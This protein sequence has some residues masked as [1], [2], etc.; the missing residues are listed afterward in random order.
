[1]H[2]SDP[3][4]LVEAV[5]DVLTSLF[6]GSG[7]PPATPATDDPPTFFW[8]RIGPAL[9]RA[10]V[11]SSLLAGLASG[12]AV[13]RGAIAVTLRSVLDED[14]RL[15]DELA[16]ALAQL[17][18]ESA[19]PGWSGAAPPSPSDMVPESAP[20]GWG[21]AAGWG[22][23]DADDVEEAESDQF[24]QFAAPGE[25]EDEDEYEDDLDYRYE[26]Y[27][28]VQPAFPPHRPPA[29]APPA[30]SGIRLPHL[31]RF[32]DLPR[33]PKLRSDRSIRG[34]AAEHR[35][36]R[37]P[38]TPSARSR[39][40]TTTA[41]RRRLVSTGVAEGSTGRTLSPR[42]TLAA[43]RSY[44]YWFAV[45]TRARTGRVDVGRNQE[46]PPFDAAEGTHLR[47]IVFPF[48]DGLQ[49]DP[50]TAEGELVVGADGGLRV[51]RQ[52]GGWSY[53]GGEDRL[54]FPFRT[55]EGPGTYRLRSSVYLGARLLQSRVLEVRVDVRQRVG[56]RR[57]VRSET[58]YS[59]SNSLSPESLTEM[60]PPRLSVMVNG[61]PAGSHDFRFVGRTPMTGTASLD[62]EKLETL[63]RNARRALRTAAWGTGEEWRADDADRY[64]VPRSPGDVQADLIAM[65]RTGYRIWDS[66]SNALAEAVPGQAAATGGRERVDR[67]TELLLHSGAVE[68]TARQS[69]RLAVPAALVYDYPLDTNRRVVRFCPGAASAMASG[70]DLAGEP[71][72][73]GAC[74]HYDDLDVVCPGGFWGYRH[75]LG[76]PLSLGAAG[77]GEAHEMAASIPGGDDPEFVVGTTTDRSFLL[78]SEHLSRLKQ[79]HTPL[80]WRL[81]DERDAVL[82]LLRTS[83]PHVVYFLC[84]GVEKDGLPGLV[85]GDPDAPSAIT[86]D[87][88]SAYR[89]SWPATR[90]LVVL[91]GCRTTALDPTKPLNF[92]ETFLRDACASGV[93]GTEITVFEPLACAFAE[94]VLHRFVHD[95]VPL[96][97]AVR[98]ARLALLSR[99]NPLGLAY[100]PYGP[101]DLRMA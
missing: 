95:D 98:A 21:D 15:R 40:T 87:N 81:G 34:R 36:I 52:P 59:V 22:P 16:L 55:P 3:A 99:G 61:G 23:G 78:R 6:R 48:P 8:L 42:T 89:N 69:M 14:A 68:L 4:A 31:P 56:T 82:D 5:L 17:H 84:H 80:T 100:V 28:D 83:S 46:L 74:P 67:L 43:G 37:L 73:D 94:E 1:V 65:A 51:G 49:L 90:P 57:A 32:G 7:F 24:E 38:R 85:V 39:L 77:Q 92:V 97:A 70:E 75:E 27:P 88:L 45:G 2:P 93:I 101:T 58:D 10:G 29:P 79:L 25:D 66:L 64:A 71:C 62:A 76:V 20:P 9:Q 35:R 12:S 19:E 26:T 13:A 63:L 72:F 60:R 50:S 54:E 33:L 53:L 96:G 30:G 18:R 11:T 44:R 41:S 47:V 86:P 91:N